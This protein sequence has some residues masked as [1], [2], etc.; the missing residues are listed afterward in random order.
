MNYASNSHIAPA[1]RGNKGVYMRS[2]IYSLMFMSIAG[3]LWDS[4]P[5]PKQ[6]EKRTAIVTTTKGGVQKTEI[7]G[8]VV[9]IVATPKVE[10]PT[11]SKVAEPE[12]AVKLEK[13]PDITDGVW[14]WRELVAKY[15]PAD[16]VHNALRIMSAENGSGNPK[17]ISK[18]NRN[19]TRDYGLFQVNTCH[20]SRVDG[21]L[22]KL[23]DAETNV[24]IASEIYKEQGW[25]PWTTHTK[26]GL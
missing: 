11:Q 12:K 5:A 13:T 8:E 3:F 25:K 22:E 21:D 16:Q 17:V 10:Q 24:R 9:K 23:Q 1:V 4:Q 15:F 7:N 6:V 2:L 18:P 20:K 19:K 26:L 14:E